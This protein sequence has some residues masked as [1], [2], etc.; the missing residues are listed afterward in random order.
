MRSFFPVLPTTPR[1]ETELPVDELLQNLADYRSKEPGDGWNKMLAVL[2]R[3]PMR[4]RG[5]VLLRSQGNTWDEVAAILHITVEAAR[6]A[7]E[8]YRDELRS[9]F[10]CFR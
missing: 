7:L 9:D 2:A 6:W 5:V 4:T 10:A 3:Y 8:A 1:L